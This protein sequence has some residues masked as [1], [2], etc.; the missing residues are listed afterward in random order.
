MSLGLENPTQ[1]LPECLQDSHIPFLET[2]KDLYVRCS[3]LVIS[4]WMQLIV[5]SNIIVTTSGQPGRSGLRSGE[6]PP[7][8][9]ND[10]RQIQGTITPSNLF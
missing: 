8:E 10:L 6:F 3:L 5:A 2:H 9:T 1:G 7:A 4:L